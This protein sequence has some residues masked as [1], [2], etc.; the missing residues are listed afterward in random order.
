MVLQIYRLLKFEKGC[1]EKVKPSK[2]FVFRRFKATYTDVNR[3]NEYKLYSDL[4]WILKIEINY[5]FNKRKNP[6]LKN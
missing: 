6:F 4:L 1:L 3:G 2:I 5:Q